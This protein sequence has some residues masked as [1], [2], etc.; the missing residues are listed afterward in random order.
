[1]QKLL[2][3]EQNRP[4]PEIECKEI[5][6]MLR[7]MRGNYERGLYKGEEYQYWQ[8]VNGLKEK[9]ELITRIPEA[10]IERSAL[11]LLSMHDS[12]EWA[13]REERKM[14]VRTMIQEAGCD[15]GAKRI[16]WVIVNPDYEILFRL[17]DGL[18]ADAGRRYWIGEHD[19]EVDIVD[20]GDELGQMVTEIKIA[21]PMSH[22]ALTRAVEYVQ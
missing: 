18:R 2:H 5:R 16:V 4:D 6:S 1:M 17:M 7:L 9:L 11:T 15:M 21:F 3:D 22:N 19:A 8:K 12:W 20:I 10:A 13:S 14:L